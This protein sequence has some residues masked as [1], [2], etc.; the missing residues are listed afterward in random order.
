MKSQQMIVSLPKLLLPLVLIFLIPGMLLAA[1]PQAENNSNGSVEWNAAANWN[2][3]AKPVDLVHTLDNKKVFILTEDHRVLIYTAKGK[4]LGAIPV[5]DGVT[6]IDIEPRGQVLYMINGKTNTFS[7]LQVDF[8]VEVNTK[9]APFLGKENAPV[10]LVIFT[11]FECPYCSKTEPLLSQVL[12]NNPDTLK[13][14]FKNMP[15]SMHKNAEPA[16][17]AALAAE[18]QGKFWQMHDALFAAD[19]L[20]KEK[21]DEIAKSIGLDMKKFQEDMK[22]PAIGQRLAR[23]LL[24]AREVGVTGT[25]TLFINGRRVKNRSLKVI[26]KMIDE[27]LAKSKK[28]AQ[29]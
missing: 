2:L 18:A 27:E 15:L 20:S 11:D 6:A 28:G 19:K 5:E 3:P 21:I 26:Q 7:S 8:V 14:V 10:S 29:K 13:I 17:R 24:D 12:E 4:K 1:T 9:G 23:D 16:A 25:P 22:S